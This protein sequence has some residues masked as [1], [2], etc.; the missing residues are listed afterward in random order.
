MLDT[1]TNPMK[2]AFLAILSLALTL[3]PQQISAQVPS[4]TPPASGE[5]ESN[6]AFW[7][8]KFNN[9]GH[10]LAKIG[11]ISSA[12][13]H[14]YIANAAARVVEVTIAASGAVVARFYYLEP[15]GKD[16]S[17]APVV[18]TINKVQS[19]A[20]KTANNISPGAADIKVVKDYPN[21]THA[22]TVEYALQSEAA[23]DSLFQSLL[24]AID[25]NRGRTW[26]ETGK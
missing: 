20:Q 15:V 11:N 4:T 9:G 7:Q 13:R 14:E 10:Y 8:A 3:I 17:I 25:L 26:L 16:S 2:A 18:N 12:S 19:L 1:T 22:H 21:T 5:Q 6:P 24:K 23:L